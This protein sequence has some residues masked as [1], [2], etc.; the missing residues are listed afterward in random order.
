MRSGLSFRSYLISMGA[1]TVLA[2]LG[3]LTII[4]R[5]DPIEAGLLGLLLFYVT[6]FAGLVGTF[7]VTG[8]LYRILW[9]KR[10]DIVVREARISFR[11][12]VMFALVSVVSLALSAQDILTW[13]NMLGV[14]I[15]I[16]AI[17]YVFVSME[18]SR[19]M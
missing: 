5:V 8:V 14:F 17:E 2:W 9:L 7:S 12:G 1:A 11:H 4:L 6:L 19:R 3:W 10:Q 15:V 18:E 16:G 13:W